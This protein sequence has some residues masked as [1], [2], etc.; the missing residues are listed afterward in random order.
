MAKLKVLSVR[1]H[2]LADIRDMNDG[3][4][5]E[6]LNDL[7]FDIRFTEKGDLTH[8]VVQIVVPAGFRTD[9]ASACWPVPKL[10]K[11]NRNYI[12]HDWGWRVNAPPF[13]KDFW[14][15]CMYQGLLAD[16]LPKYR[17]YT[18]LIGVRTPIGTRTWNK[19]QSERNEAIS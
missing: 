14:D 11:G 6:L 12:L 4:N 2:Q 18:R 19:Y 1:C 13:E 10:T 5:F 8:S 16:D 15:Q 9:L 3:E 17:A 7:V